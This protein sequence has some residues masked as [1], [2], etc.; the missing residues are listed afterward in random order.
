MVIPVDAPMIAADT[1]AKLV[2]LFSSSTAPIVRARYQG[3][4]GHPV[5]FSR[6]VFDELHRADPALGAKA[7]LRAHHD[8]I[9]N[10]DV[11]DPGVA[12]D[13]DTPQDYENLVNEG[14]E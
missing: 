4:N 6:T 5:V 14:N 8:A 2:A 1:V 3:R 12:G 11:D 9:L 7:V 10:L 13:I